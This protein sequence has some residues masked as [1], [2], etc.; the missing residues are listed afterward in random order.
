MRIISSGLTRSAALSAIV[1][2]VASL[3]VACDKRA[4]AEKSEPAPVSSGVANAAPV[5]S[6]SPSPA[7]TAAPTVEA[8]TVDVTVTANG[9]TMAFEPTSLTVPAGSNVHLT[10]ENKKPGALEH[11]WALVNPGTEAKVAADGLAKGEAANYIAEGSDLLAYT[12]LAKAGGDKVEV[13]FKA[14]P[15][16]KYPYICTFPGHYMMMKGT[17]TV[18]P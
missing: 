2:A 1:I 16:G 6:P 11:N 7:Q 13:T 4:N 15:A 5:P 8:K 18:T 14:P 12:P 17:L 10:L 9:A 3:A